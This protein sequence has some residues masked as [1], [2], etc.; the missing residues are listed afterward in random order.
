MKSFI[1]GFSA[2]LI[3]SSCFIEKPAIKAVPIK[4]PSKTAISPDFR[5][6]FLNRINRLRSQGCNCGNK[7]QNPV[8][9]LIWN[10]ELE[11][12][13]LGHAQDMSRNRYFDHKSKNGQLL[14]DRLFATGYT[15]NGYQ[16]YFIGENI[17]M[18]QHY[19][20]EVMEGWIISEKHCKNLMNPDF[21]EVGIAVI[22]SYWVQDFGARNPFPSRSARR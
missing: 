1:L 11:L 14:I 15:Y 22:N 16:S 21:K 3:F 17:A 6:D 10:N 13:A 7:Y 19:I 5:E 18:G 12:A 2:F 20:R 8:P 9:P 4:A